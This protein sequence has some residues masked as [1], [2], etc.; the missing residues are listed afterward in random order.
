VTLCC[1]RILNTP[2]FWQTFSSVQVSPER[3]KIV[4]TLTPSE[5]KGK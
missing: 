4:G 3:Y 5:T 2:D 1:E